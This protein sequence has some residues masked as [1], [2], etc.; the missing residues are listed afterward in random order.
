MTVS[1]N[2]TKIKNKK[3]SW[4]GFTP[5]KVLFKVRSQKTITTK[6]YL[7][8]QKIDI[9]L[10]ISSNALQR[11]F[12]GMLSGKTTIQAYKIMKGC[13]QYMAL[14]YYIYSMTLTM[15]SDEEN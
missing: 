1:N 12:N 10:Y 5:S 4:P 7:K 15:N 6:V 8:V 11:D 2:T 3:S 9:F 13:I 14:S